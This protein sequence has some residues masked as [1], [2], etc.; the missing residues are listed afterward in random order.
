MRIC[1]ICTEIFEWG[2]YGGFGRATRL[3]GRELVKRGI[4]VF[5]VIPRRNEQKE[6]EIL[7]GIKVLGFHKS[8]PFYVR[9]L[10]RE[11]NADIFHSEEPSL[12]TYLAIKEMPGKLHLVTS[13]DPKVLSDWFN[14]FI[15]PSYNKLQVLSN[16]LFEDNSLVKRSVRQADRVF[17]AAI[18]LK[19][20]IVHKY[21]LNNDVEFL[22]TPIKIP[23]YEINKADT[24]TVCFISRWDKRKKPEIFFRLAEA[25]P[26]IKFIAVGKGRNKNYDNYLRKKY[27]SLKN[28]I[29]TG[30]I[31][32]FESNEIDEI[33]DKSWILVN[34][35]IREGLPNSFLEALAHKCAILSSLNPENVTKCFGY[36]VSNNNFIEG[37]KYLLK[38]DSWKIKGE[39]GQA[40]VKENYEL[41]IAIEKHIK[42][43][44]D[45][46][47]NNK[48]LV[49]H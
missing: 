18:F 42:I 23:T 27:S 3:I 40:Y 17:S 14:E 22:P 49:W 31:N 28:L 11:C 9:K 1:F 10:F 16:F 41:N 8:N 44:Q 34:T 19:N 35:A 33:L 15:L 13:R 6:F 43:Y 47:T 36:V 26:D 2:K 12:G 30:F 45:L 46:L 24:P 7:D 48:H 21:T 37:L 32:Q 25:L 5:A 4:E 29:I 38:E 20:K 39:E